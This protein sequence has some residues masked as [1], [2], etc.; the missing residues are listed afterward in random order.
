MIEKCIGLC[1]VYQILNLCTRMSLNLLF[2]ILTE[3]YVFL[4][5]KPIKLWSY[6][7]NTRYLGY[8]KSAAVPPP[9]PTTVTHSNS[10]CIEATP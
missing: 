2:Y 8:S 6:K 3:D 1:I 5:W 9:T 7:K 10:S 4:K